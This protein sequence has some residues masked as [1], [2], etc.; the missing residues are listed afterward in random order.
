MKTRWYIYTLEYYSAI[1]QII[2][3][4]AVW[5]NQ[6]IILCELSQRETD[7]TLR[8]HVEVESINSY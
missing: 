5:M 3:L 2:I 8:Y 4:A 1:E 7:N 6:E